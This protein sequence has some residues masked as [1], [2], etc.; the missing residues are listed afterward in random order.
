MGEISGPAFT[1]SSFHFQS[2]SLLASYWVPPSPAA[3]RVGSLPAKIQVDRRY[4]TYR[5]VI[6][7]EQLA[8]LFKIPVRNI[9]VHLSPTLPRYQ[10]QVMRGSWT[11]RRADSGR[12]RTLRCKLEQLE[13]TY[14]G[15]R[16]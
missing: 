4:P 5:A 14:K 13:H 1:L 9:G 12:A 7:N 3:V 11:D 15:N 16:W 6:M 8:M 10:R 2:V